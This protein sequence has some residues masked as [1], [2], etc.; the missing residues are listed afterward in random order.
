MTIGGDLK[1]QYN[2]ITWSGG[3]CPVDGDEIV[4]VELLSGDK[5]EGHLARMC[6][7]QWTDPESDQHIIAY[8]VVENEVTGV[9][10][11]SGK[12]EYS[13]MPKGALHETVK[14][15]TYGAKKYSPD[16]WKRVP[17]LQKRYFDALQRHIYAYQ[18]GENIDPESGL[19]H[20]A[21]ASC[22]INFMLQ[23][24]LDQE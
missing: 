7:W 4:D 24:A 13:L 3:D 20:L 18:S 22:C 1:A 16:N 21:H 14:V 15:L 9:K 19:H 5:H 12:P 2:W 17:E 23:D 6:C 8:R 10:Y 11:D